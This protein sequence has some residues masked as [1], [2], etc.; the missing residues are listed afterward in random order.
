MESIA[1]ILNN[2]VEKIESLTSTLERM[3][4]QGTLTYQT[5][6]MAAVLNMKQQEAPPAAAKRPRVEPRPDANKGPELRP[7]R[8]R[9]MCYYLIFFVSL[10]RLK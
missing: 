5:V 8:N 1:A 9:I 4:T 10:F 7:P 6:S 3:Q 2:V